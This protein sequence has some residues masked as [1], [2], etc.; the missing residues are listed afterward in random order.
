[1][2]FNNWFASGLGKDSRWDEELTCE[3]TNEIENIDH[4]NRRKR[5]ALRELTKV[6][7]ERNAYI[8]KLEN[9]IDILTDEIDGLNCWIED[10]L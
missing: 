10:L 5:K 1:M 9:E 3:L 4:A 6:V 2:K 8:E 7:E